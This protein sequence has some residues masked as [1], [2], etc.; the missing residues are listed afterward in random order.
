MEHKSVQQDF[1]DFQ[2]RCRTFRLVM[3]VIMIWII[4]KGL[5]L[6]P[7]TAMSHLQ[8]HF[9]IDEWLMVITGFITIQILMLSMYPEIKYGGK[10]KGKYWIK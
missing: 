7:I 6:Y 9:R 2:N 4:F 5:I 1:V 3:C 10:T 8:M